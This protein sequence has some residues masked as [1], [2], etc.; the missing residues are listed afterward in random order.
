[1]NSRVSEGLSVPAPLEAPFVLYK[2]SDVMIEERTGK[3]LRQV[4]RIVICDT[5][6]L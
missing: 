1:V 6:I 4:E 5:D 2:H 3:C